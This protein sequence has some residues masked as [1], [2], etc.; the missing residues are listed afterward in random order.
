MNNKLKSKGGGAALYINDNLVSRHHE[1]P[2]DTECE[3]VWL[4]YPIVTILIYL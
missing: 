1:V 4:K 3:A 2:P